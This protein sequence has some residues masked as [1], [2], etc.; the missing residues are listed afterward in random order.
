[1]DRKAFLK[2]AKKHGWTHTITRGSHMKFTKPG[3]RAVITSY[4]GSDSHCYKNAR[5][6]MRR[7]ERNTKPQPQPTCTHPNREDGAVHLYCP[8]CGAIWERADA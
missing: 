7:A 5:A 3:C 2:W 4:T 6:Q 8:D 1:M